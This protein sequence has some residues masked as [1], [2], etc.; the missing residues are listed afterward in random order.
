[1]KSLRV[2]CAL[3]LLV[4]S[5]SFSFAAGKIRATESDSAD[6]KQYASIA[7][8]FGNKLSPSLLSAVAANP[9]KVQI[10][11]NLHARADHGATGFQLRQ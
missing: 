3:S 11:V 4:V 1:V 6:L 2:L 8:R 5:S 9:E 7:T 10:I